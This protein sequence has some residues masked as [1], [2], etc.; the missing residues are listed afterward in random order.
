MFL[1][2][3]ES[4]VTLL[5]EKTRKIENVP[6]ELGDL[7]KTSRQATEGATLFFMLFIVNQV[8]TELP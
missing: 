2:G 5:L 6:N 1:C 4:L 7:G 3:T 8:R